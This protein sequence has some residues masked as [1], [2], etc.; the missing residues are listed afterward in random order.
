MLKN[1]AT[2]TGLIVEVTDK[3]QNI[4]FCYRSP[5]VATKRTDCFIVKNVIAV[6]TKP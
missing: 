5:T 6:S 3:I 1:A 4:N 2:V